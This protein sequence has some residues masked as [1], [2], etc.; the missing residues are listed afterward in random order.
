[1]IANIGSKMAVTG[2]SLCQS[3]MMHCIV[4]MFVP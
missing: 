4:C 3:A 2:A 1:M